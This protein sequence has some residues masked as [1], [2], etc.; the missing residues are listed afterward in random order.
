VIVRGVGRRFSA[1]G[2]VSLL[3]AHPESVPKLI[4]EVHGAARAVAALDAPVI[5]SVHCVAAG[6]GM[7]PVAACD[8]AIAADAM[9]FKSVL[10]VAATIGYQ[11]PVHF[12]KFAASRAGGSGGEGAA[13]NAE[14]QQFRP[15]LWR[16]H[17]VTHFA[18]LEASGSSM[19]ILSPPNC[20]AEAVMRPSW[21][22]TM[23]RQMASPSP[24]PPV[25]RLREA[26]TR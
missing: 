10:E 21:A 5:A 1:G 4:A 23:L 6:A 24:L 15:S 14:A 8:L 3:A 11:D 18:H 2:D 9:R 19:A 25:A 22:S 20:D 12:N 26:S 13:P 16:Q 17:G 7:S